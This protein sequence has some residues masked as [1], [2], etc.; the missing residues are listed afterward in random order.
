MERGRVDELRGLQEKLEAL[1]TKIAQ[2]ERMGDRATAADM[3]YYAVPDIE[4]RIKELVVESEKMRDRE[5]GEGTEHMMSEEV[6]LC[7]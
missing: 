3:K 7:V 4:K 6:I 1:K 2:A 5:T